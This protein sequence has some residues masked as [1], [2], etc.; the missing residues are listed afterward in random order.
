MRFPALF[1]FISPHAPCVRPF[2]WPHPKPRTFSLG[3]K[4]CPRVPLAPWQWSWS[5]GHATLSPLGAPRPEGHSIKES[6]GQGAE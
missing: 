3:T 6:P 2:P 4:A 1:V 5:Q